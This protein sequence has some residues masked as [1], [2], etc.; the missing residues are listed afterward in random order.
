MQHALYTVWPEILTELNLAIWR[1]GIGSPN[2]KSPEL[3]HNYYT[4]MVAQL[5]L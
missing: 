5:Q 3:L 4:R 1:F 2:F